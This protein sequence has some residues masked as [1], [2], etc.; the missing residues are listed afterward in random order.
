MN[1]FSFAGEQALSK[2]VNQAAVLLKYERQRLS[3]ADV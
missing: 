3:K 1:H 2:Q